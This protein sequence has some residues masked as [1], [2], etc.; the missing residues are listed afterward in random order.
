[1]IE[2]VKYLNSLH[3]DGIK[4]HMLNIVKDTALANLYKQK[5]FHILSKEEYIDIVISQL[6]YLDPKIVIHRITSDPDPQNL[7]EP[8]W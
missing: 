2:T 7:I 5:N 8:K 4:I 1:M 3:I 6:E